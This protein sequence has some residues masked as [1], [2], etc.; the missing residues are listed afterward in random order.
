MHFGENFIKQKLQG[1]PDLVRAGQLF[2]PQIR[3]RKDLGPMS[4][5]SHGYSLWIAHKIKVAIFV[6]NSYLMGLDISY[7]DPKVWGPKGG[8]SW[9]LEPQPCILVDTL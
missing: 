5:W 1:T 3:I 4:F 2:V 8:P 7:C 9:V 6:P